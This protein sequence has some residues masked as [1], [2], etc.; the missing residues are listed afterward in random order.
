MIKRIDVFMPPLSTYGVLHH[1]TKKMYEALVRCGVKA[2]LLEAKRDDPGS[3]LKILFADPPECTLSFNGLLPDDQGRFFSD[4][5]RIPH[6]ACLVDSPN[7]F[8]PLIKS[9]YTIITTVDRS[10]VDFFKGLGFDEAL[11]LPHAVEK[12]LHAD[13]KDA[14]DYDVVVLASCID[15]EGIRRSWKK[16][17][18]V[19]LIRAMDETAE[20]ALD[21]STKPYYQIFAEALDRQISGQTGI[22]PRKVDFV[23]VLDEVEMYIRGKDRV[24]LVKSIND[25]KV[26]IFGAGEEGGWK[27]YLDNKRNVR[28]HDPVP[29]EQA[30]A[31]MKHTKIILNSC[32]W[33]HYGGHE[34][35]FSGIA[36]GALVITNENEYLK[37][38]F[39]DGES[40]VFY[41]HGHM[42]KANYRVNEY[43]ENSA[44]RER[45]VQKGREIVMN[46]DTWDQRAEQLLKELPPLLKKM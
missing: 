9:N 16:K 8:L 14:R 45:V 27:K 12:E 23:S 3:F 41:R 28:I 21:D 32:P 11:F 36:C 33:I 34:R 24:D 20:I 25:A 39:I 6:V 2:R 31:I 40:I 43:L 15:Y 4:M 46:A 26:D 42:N 35:I 5:I 7:S 37:Q 13:P 19:P 38:Q 17:F 22:D 44:K 30:L 18:S 10:S 29:F 1:F